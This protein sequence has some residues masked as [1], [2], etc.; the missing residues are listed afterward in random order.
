[1]AAMAKRAAALVLILIACGSGTQGN[2]YGRRQQ[3]ATS[4]AK[5]VSEL[6]EFT[7]NHNDRGIAH[8]LATPL[9]Y[10]GLWFPDPTCRRQFGPA[11][12]IPE[13]GIDIF[14][15]CMSR[16]HLVKSTRA[17][18]FPDVAVFTY[19]PGLEIEALFDP[20]DGG[21]VTWI[22]Y[23][24]RRDLKDALPTVTQEALIPLRNE[25][26]PLVVDDAIRAE[27]DREVSG[28]AAYAWFKV[29]ID[30]TGA[31]T[32]VHPR[33][34]SSLV[35]QDVL[36]P[37]VKTWSFKSFKLGDQ[38]SPVCSLMYLD[39]PAGSSQPTMTPPP[40]PPEQAGAIVVS[41]DAFG[42][43]LEGD[44]TITPDGSAID[45]ARA[46]GATTLGATVMYCLDDI[47]KVET[48]VIMQSTG[49]PRLDKEL[50]AKAL[51]W[52]FAPFTFRGTPTRACTHTTLTYNVPVEAKR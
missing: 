44:Q 34:A 43:L 33:L 6:V 47:G 13:S 2:K 7:T 16:L 25:V 49:S 5:L 24:G 23:A 35:A 40:V 26:P 1:M 4:T 28:R 17:H 45:E 10:G 46:R 15:T 48:A 41:S 9:G 18:L 19:E 52:R 30:A 32:G 27:I 14:A 31:V 36:A 37:W 20:S 3:V 12:L 38:P 11:G 29:C 50:T 42:P 21:H 51:A 22:G 8:M 39:L